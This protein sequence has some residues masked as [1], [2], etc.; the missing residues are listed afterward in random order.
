MSAASIAPFDAPNRRQIAQGHPPDWQPPRPRNVY[1]LV[2]IEGGPCGLTAALTAARRG[3]SVA[4][5]ERNLTGRSWTATV[6]HENS[7]PRLARWPLVLAHSALLLS[8][9]RGLRHW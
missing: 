6:A 4:L 9:Q 8:P 5:A 7:A 2:V 1:D 3:H